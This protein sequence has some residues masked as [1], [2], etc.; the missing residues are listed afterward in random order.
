M[1]LSSLVVFSA[2]VSSAEEWG[3]LFIFTAVE[4]GS[5][6]ADWRG[7]LWMRRVFE[8]QAIVPPRDGHKLQITITKYNY[9]LP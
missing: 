9:K 7:R 4:D 2:A 5:D 8:P 3:L 6:V 1:D